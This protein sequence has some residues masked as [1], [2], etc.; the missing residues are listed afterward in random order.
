MRN[1]SITVADLF[2]F[3]YYKC[4]RS[5]YA[6]NECSLCIDI[7]PED[8]MVFDRARLTLDADRCT[9]CAACMGSC[10]TEALISDLFDPNRFVLEFS[11]SENRLL[12]C[13]ENVPCL[14]ALSSEH[15]ISIVLRKED[16]AICDLSHCSECAINRDNKVLQTIENSIDESNRFLRLCNVPGGISVKTDRLENEVE[17]ERRGMFKKLFQASREIQEDASMA[18]LVP[19]EHEKQPLK[20][21]MLK[22]SLKRIAADLEANSGEIP[23]S[24][25]AGKLIDPDICNNCQECAMFCPSEALSILK[26]NT[27]IVFQQ[28][29]CIACGIC[30][31]LC[32]SKAITNDPRL[33]LVNFAFDRMDLL[34]KHTLEICEECK[35]AFPYRGG[36]KVCDR[37]AD[38]K[39][40]F[41]DIFTLAKDME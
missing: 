29:R 6:K 41:S 40:H 34:V 24:F 22:N 3:N 17:M 30:D 33:D 12:S 36:E 9:G 35:V 19:P 16:E 1:E 18:E 31:D 20:R 13:K 10:P 21:I 5:E 38:Y 15:L 39:D 26:D 2:K 25:V 11:A 14:A 28:G 8:A 32:Q 27:G 7:C 37:C 23:F 4:L